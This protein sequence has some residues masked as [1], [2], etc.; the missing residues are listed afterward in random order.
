MS[1]MEIRQMRPNQK[2]QK[3]D[4]ERWVNISSLQEY[5]HKSIR[6]SCM[7][8]WMMVHKAERERGRVIER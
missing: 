7:Y 6:V 1:K 5:R 4:D 3:I 8:R 2:R